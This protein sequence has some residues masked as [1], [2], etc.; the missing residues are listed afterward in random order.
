MTVAAAARVVIV[1]GIDGSGPDHWQSRWEAD[2]G[3]RAVR[4]APAS[5][6]EPEVG[7][8][9][10]AIGRVAEPGMIVVAHSLGCLAV[11]HWLGDAAS[12]RIGAVMLVAPPDAGGSSFPPIA[13]P[14]ALPAR[15]LPVPAMVVASDDDPYAD[16]A[17]VTALAG[18]WGAE[19]V[20]IPGAGHLNTASGLDDWPHGRALLALLADRAH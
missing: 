20:V 17:A 14:F 6:S 12:A 10:A 13:S 16:L 8:W 11:A 7:D 15:R 1:P 3:D 2:L 19:L 9:V 5:W 4:I 18:A